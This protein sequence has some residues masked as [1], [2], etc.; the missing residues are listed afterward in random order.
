MI[1]RLIQKVGAGR[2]FLA[3]VCLVYIVFGLF[4]PETALAGLRAFVKLLI[5][6]LPALAI[7]FALLFLS[8]LLVDSRAVSR[9][10]GKGSRRGGWLIAILAG[11]VSAGPIYLW[12]PLLSDLKEKGMREALIATFLYNRAVKIPLLPMM[13]LYF[14]TRLVVILTAYMIVFSVLNGIIVEKILPERKEEV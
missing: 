2:L 13:I 8:N 5:R 7:V 14:G 9:F 12:Y 1:R 4:S 10:L 3:A 6:M 11:I